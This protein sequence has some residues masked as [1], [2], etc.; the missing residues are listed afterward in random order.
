MMI[1]AAILA[2]AVLV[3]SLSLAQAPCMARA[4]MERMLSARYGE[5]V[6]MRGFSAS[7]LYMT[8]VW[9]SEAGTFTV[10]QTS[11]RGV[12]CALADGV[13]IEPVTAPAQPKGDPS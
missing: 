7:G 5:A 12:S 11:V 13:A 6:V 2:A 1:R 3:P 10:V 4:D 8:E 9:V